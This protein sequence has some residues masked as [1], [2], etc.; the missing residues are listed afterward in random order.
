[1]VQIKKGGD[2][3]ADLVTYHLLQVSVLSRLNTCLS[4]QNT[5]FVAT[6]V[7]LPR[8]TLCRDIIMFVATKYF[9]RQTRGLSRQI[10]VLRDNFFVA[11]KM[12]LVAAPASDS[13]RVVYIIIS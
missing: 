8:Q 10:L 3:V 4:R 6:K 12:I 5:S 2:T 9:L 11:I 1:M 7:C 13:H